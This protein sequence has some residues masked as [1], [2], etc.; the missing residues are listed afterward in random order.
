MEFVTSSTSGDIDWQLPRSQRDEKQ[1]GMKKYSSLSE[2]SNFANQRRSREI[3]MRALT[4][5]KTGW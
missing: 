4:K 1:Q 3:N 5:R 2:Q